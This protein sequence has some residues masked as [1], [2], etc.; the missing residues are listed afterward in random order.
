MP[1]AGS[2]LGVY[3]PGLQFCFDS[4]LLGGLSNPVLKTRFTCVCVC[5]YVFPCLWVP[6]EAQ[7]GFGSPGADATGNLR[8]TWRGAGN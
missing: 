2:R 7:R 4:V 1:C 3:L 6:T 5:M 8:I